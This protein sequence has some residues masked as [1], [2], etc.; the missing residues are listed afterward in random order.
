MET[1]SKKI[2]NARWL[3][4]MPVCFF[5]T[6]FYFIDRQII[7]IALPGGVQQ[8]LALDSTMSGLVAGVVS[9]GILFLSVPAGQLAQ[10]GTVKKFIGICI[11]GWSIFTIL[12]G[13]VENSWQLIIVRFFIGFFEGAFSPG[14]TTIFTFWFPDKDGERT[15]ANS[16]YFT[17]ISVA[18]ISMGPIGG[19]LIQ[20]YGWRNL[21]II[22]GVLSLGAF[23]LWQFF[24]FDRPGQAKWLSKEEKDYIETTIEEER[25]RAKQVAGDIQVK[26]EKLPLGLLL[27]N[28]YVWS[29]CIVGFTVNIGQFGYTIWMPTLIKSITKTNILNVGL[30]SI[31]P[32]IF[33]LI[34]LWTWSYIATK[35]SS[36]RL[37]TGLPL[38]MFG[39][40]LI[41]ANVI[42]DS[43]TPVIQI[44]LIC[45]V[46]LFIQGHMPSYYSIPSLVLVKEL[47]GPA[48]GMMAVAMGLGSFV[49]P[50]A[51]GY[52]TTI[53][54]SAK[55][56]MYFLT[57][58]LIIG[59]ISTL[60]LPKNMTGNS[61]KDK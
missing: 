29:L 45:I 36:R 49:G 11:A 8:A 47:D 6:F 51:V 18:A 58:M 60:M 14:I 41:I 26:S 46:S 25:E 23:L 5:T 13:F 33:T 52:L 30:I 21:F 32:S 1:S 59:G 27:R 50:Y 10:K 53:T 24:I 28:K 34:G 20:F 57:V 31:I 48:R 19:T 15:R 17:A 56:G 2:P 35:V 38:I 42:G 3:Y 55:T 61:K 22:L 39:A 4:I 16:T 9:I 12:T 54:G 44:G 37:T 43:L 40:S 7:S